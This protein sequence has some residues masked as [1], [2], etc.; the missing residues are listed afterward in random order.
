MEEHPVEAA[1]GSVGRV[2]ILRC[3]LSSPRP[4]SK[5]ALQKAT[6]LKS[7]DVKRDLDKLVSA[8]WVKV[9]KSPRAPDKYSVDRESHAVKALEE[10]F[11]ALGYI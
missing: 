5:Y 9:V 10:F 6:G 4:L 2:R 1:L 8:G 7:V 11:R 3:L